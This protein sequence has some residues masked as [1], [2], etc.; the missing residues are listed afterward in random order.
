MGLSEDLGMRLHPPN[1]A[2]RLVQTVAATRS[3]SWV[4]SRTLPVLDSVAQRVTGRTLPEVF[5]SLPVVQ[6]TTS[7]RRTGL[8]HTSHLV[9]I[10]HNEGLAVIGTNF[11]QRD[12]PAWVLNLEADPTA[13]VSFRGRSHRVVA[14][15][16]R[17]AERETIMALA[18]RTYSGYTVY[19][20]RITSREIRVFVLELSQGEAD[21]GL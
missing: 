4:F 13:T 20:E 6:V 21:L 17:P 8:A 12:T 19:R 2:Q 15:P 10:P 14:R 7:G 3:G 16:A 5:A 9:A 11:A 1:P 18:D